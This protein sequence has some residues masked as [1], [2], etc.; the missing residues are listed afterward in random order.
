MGGSLPVLHLMQS[1]SENR[2]RL[3]LGELILQ[4]KHPDQA[5]LTEKE[6]HGWREGKVGKSQILI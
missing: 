1:I 5:S 4:Q 2:D 6:K 3:V